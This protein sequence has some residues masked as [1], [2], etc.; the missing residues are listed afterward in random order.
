MFVPCEPL[1]WVNMDAVTE[2]LTVSQR[3]T[4]PRFL[5]KRAATFC[6][7][8]NGGDIPQHL[9]GCRAKRAPWKQPPSGRPCGRRDTACQDFQRGAENSIRQ[10][11]L[12]SLLKL[13]ECPNLDIFFPTSNLLCP[14]LQLQL[15]QPI[16]DPS[17]G[18]AFFS[19]LCTYQWTPPLYSAWGGSVNAA[20]EEAK[21]ECCKHKNT[22][23]KIMIKWCASPNGPPSTY[24]W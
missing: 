12:I 8:T 16:D 5:L 23:G 18:P 22:F 3:H 9:S 11:W 15:Y 19:T 7:H 17:V 13:P 6:L 21:E 20:R 10:Q 14:P 2:V 4:G 1:S 24:C